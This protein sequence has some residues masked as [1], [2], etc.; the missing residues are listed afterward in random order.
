MH[1]FNG[2]LLMKTR[3]DNNNEGV[4]LERFQLLVPFG[5][6]VINALFLMDSQFLLTNNNNEMNTLWYDMERGMKL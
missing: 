2:T 4:L 3:N 5:I 6:E 1:V